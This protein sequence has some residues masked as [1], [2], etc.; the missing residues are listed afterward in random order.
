MVD[1]AACWP[2]LILTGLTYDSIG[3][4]SP[5]TAEERLV[6]LGRRQNTEKFDPQPYEQLAKVLKATGHAGEA[7]RILIEKE[8]DYARRKRQAAGTG[9]QWLHVIWL[10]LMD[11]LTRHGYEPWRVLPYVLAVWAL[12][13]GIY[14]DTD[15]HFAMVPAKERVYMSEKYQEG[16]LPPQYPRFNAFIYSVDVFFPF[17]DLH[18]ESEWRPA[19]EKVRKDQSEFYAHNGWIAKVYTWIHIALGWGS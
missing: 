8:R 6:W 2:D 9:P 11:K 16:A 5:Q 14:S 18:Q 3:H 17:V 7:R 10:W 1:E 19:T 13:W 15:R 12:G 4:G